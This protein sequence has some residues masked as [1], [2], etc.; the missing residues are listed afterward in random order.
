MKSKN[1]FE[2][3]IYF[4]GVLV[5]TTLACGQFE[6]GIETPNKPAGANSPKET[7][8]TNPENTPENQQPDLSN[9]KSWM[10]TAPQAPYSLPAEFAGLIFRQDNGLWLV[11]QGGVPLMAA[12]NIYDGSLSP[13]LSQLVYANQAEDLNLLDLD[14]GES[15]KLTD[16][17]NILEGSV[18]WWTA[19][20]GVLIYNFM[21][22]EELGPWSGFLGAYDLN[23]TEIKVLDSVSR[24]WHGFALSPDGSAILY[25]DAGIP[26]I[27]LWGEGISTL[28]MSSYGINY[29]NYSAPA[30]SPDGKTV[31]FHAIRNPESGGPSEAAIVL[32]N[33]ENGQAR[34]FHP[35]QSAGKRGPAEIA[36]SPDGRWLA[37]VTHGEMEVLD[38]GPMAL[39]VIAADQSEEHYL[40]YG[41]GPIWSPTGNILLF[42]K[43]PAIGTGGGSFQ[44]DAH[45]MMVDSATWT[46]QEVAPLL[47]SSLFNW[48]PSP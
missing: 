41:T 10:D 46:A 11:E 38:T 31:A 35:Y 45:T 44:E 33:L 1:N 2:L 48:Y 17:P 6:V 3:L 37:V 24:S 29:Q 47:G 22:R 16:T 43:W 14:T 39:W 12:E 18:Q 5:L 13:D 21:D 9:A 25:D 19:K 34:E 27:Y 7:N 30:W 15:I 32:I 8:G 28:D 40:G 20:P 42:T 4:L 26:V 23:T 36:F